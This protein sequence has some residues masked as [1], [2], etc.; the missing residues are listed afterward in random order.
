MEGGQD[1][2]QVPQACTQKDARTNMHT[3]TCALAHIYT[4]HNIYV[5]THAHMHRGRLTWTDG[6]VFDG[7]FKGGEYMGELVPKGS[8]VTDMANK[9]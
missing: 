9:P 5:R 2:G 4:H 6:D 1:G 7:R 8:D 3:R